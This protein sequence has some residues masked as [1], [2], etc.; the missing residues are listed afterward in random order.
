MD[1]TILLIDNRPA[2]IESFRKIEWG[3][4]F[5]VKICSS[6]Q[7]GIALLKKH[8]VHLVFIANLLS[9]MDVVRFMDLKNQIERAELIPVVVLSDE[10][11]YKERIQ[12]MLEGIDDYFFIPYIGE[13]LETRARILLKEVY[14]IDKM[15]KRSSKGFSGNL[16]EMILLDLL[17]TLELGRKT[18]IINLRRN[19][20]EAQVFV[21]DGL[22]YDAELDSKFGEEALFSL[23]SWTDGH[24][25]VE[26]RPIERVRQIQLSTQE[27]TIRGKKILEEWETIR[28]QFSNLNIKPQINKDFLEN[29]IM[30]EWKQ[31]VPLLDGSKSIKRILEFS[32]LSEVQ[33]LSYILQMQ[34]SGFIRITLPDLEKDI[35]SELSDSFG[36]EYQI[37]SEKLNQ[38]INS[39]IDGFMG[40][41]K[42]DKR[43]KNL[44]S[45]LES[46]STNDKNRKILTKIMFESVELQYIKQKL[47]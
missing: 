40:R 21:Q 46:P 11:N 3:D 42:P 25:F 34:N 6:G 39:F 24:F 15:A 18:G 16:S 14:N 2:N 35:L 1:Y 17:Q 4:E 8:P 45:Q 23:F 19:L 5:S 31:I 41:K 22:V 27:L 28:S 13:E 37:D 30:P 44:D 26:F 32:P 29:G 20:K 33:S 10:P 47:L 9:D 7:D 43:M 36:G 38:T 12:H